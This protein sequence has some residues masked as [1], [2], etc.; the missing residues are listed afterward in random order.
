M[1]VR[2]FK[3]TDLKSVISLNKPFL[4]EIL[5]W[6]SLVSNIE[7]YVIKLFSECWI[8]SIEY[9][10]S[11]GMSK[12]YEQTRKNERIGKSHPRHHL[13]TEPKNLNSKEN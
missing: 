8:Q 1:S 11:G 7:Y 12:N 9:E 5:S 6:T 10:D 3:F 13:D 2:P 4:F